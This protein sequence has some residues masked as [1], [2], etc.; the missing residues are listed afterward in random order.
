[1]Y[2][3]DTLDAVRLLASKI[4][5]DGSLQGSD[6][7]DTMKDILTALGA[8]LYSGAFEEALKMRLETDAVSLLV[9]KVLALKNFTKNDV[10]LLCKVILL[11]SLAH[12]GSLYNYSY[13]CTSNRRTTQVEPDE[14]KTLSVFK[15][16]PVELQSA[17]VVHM[18]SIY[19][20]ISEVDYSLRA[21]ENEAMLRLLITFFKI[22]MSVLFLPK[23]VFE[24]L[25]VKV[26]RA[27]VSVLC[28]FHGGLAVLFSTHCRARGVSMAEPLYRS[29]NEGN[30]HEFR[31]VWLTPFGNFGCLLER[32]VSINAAGLER[33][34]AIEIQD[35]I[36]WLKEV[37]YTGA[38]LSKGEI[39]SIDIAIYEIESEDL[40]YQKREEL[41]GEIEDDISYT[42]NKARYNMLHVCPH[43]AHPSGRSNLDNTYRR[44]REDGESWEIKQILRRSV[45]VICDKYD[46]RDIPQKMRN[47]VP[48]LSCG[49]KLSL[50]CFPQDF[51]S[52]SSSYI[53]IKSLSESYVLPVD[54]FSQH[55][56]IDLGSNAAYLIDLPWGKMD[57]RSH[58]CKV[59]LEHVI[60]LIEDM[61]TPFEVIK[62]MKPSLVNK[63]PKKVLDKLMDFERDLHAVKGKGQLRTLLN[64][65]KKTPLDV[66]ALLEKDGNYSEKI[67]GYAIALMVK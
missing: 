3:I 61:S 29:I 9:D 28:N 34:D 52:Q 7:S 14:E 67:R 57:D 22:N 18:L 15:K 64:L 48:L 60:K 46:K 13:S 53:P 37:N 55:D 54:F 8:N 25:S 42:L 33:G 49:E 6:A 26:K 50:Q 65:N 16:L 63:I 59:A 62:S 21:P 5:S 10:N 58:F 19:I 39:E 17:C 12:S 44:Y 41:R 31:D 38:L 66:I 27:Y 40:K 43:L 47:L 11:Q 24:T 30:L 20:S 2:V 23:G 1:M 36:I 56:L 35:L 32:Y 45:H 51:F 4:E